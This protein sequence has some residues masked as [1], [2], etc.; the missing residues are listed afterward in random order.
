MS[1]QTRDGVPGIAVDRVCK[2]RKGGR[3]KKHGA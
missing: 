1:I 3:G 2:E